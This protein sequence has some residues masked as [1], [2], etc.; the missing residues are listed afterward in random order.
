MIYNRLSYLPPHVHKNT[1]VQGSVSVTEFLYQGI[2]LDPLLSD[3]DPEFRKQL[4]PENPFNP[5]L[6]SELIRVRIVPLI[7]I[8]LSSVMR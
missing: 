5:D 6:A 2:P 8:P 4:H 3:L 1:S 7:S